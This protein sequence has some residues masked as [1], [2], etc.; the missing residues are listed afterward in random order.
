[1]I[2]VCCFL[3]FPSML[4]KDDC[5]D[6]KIENA[7]VQECGTLQQSNL[8]SKLH[9]SWRVSTRSSLYPYLMEWKSPLVSTSIRNYSLNLVN[10]KSLSTKYLLSRN[11]CQVPTLLLMCV[12]YFTD[13]DNT[14]EFSYLSSGKYHFN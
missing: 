8:F 3:C 9:H 2:Y 11:F 12:F 14:N 5:I 10:T 13:L 4:H 6:S 1:M 7:I